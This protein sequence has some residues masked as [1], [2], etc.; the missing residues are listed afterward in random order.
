MPQ[1]ETCLFSIR[2]EKLF[3]VMVRKKKGGAICIIKIIFIFAIYMFHACFMLIVSWEGEN[4]FMVLIF[5]SSE[6]LF[7][8]RL[9]EPNNFW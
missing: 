2:P 8:V 7:S 9:Q 3:L 6:E 5:L 4:N 1:S